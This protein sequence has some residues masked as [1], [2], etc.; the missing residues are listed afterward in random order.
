MDSDRYFA[1]PNDKLKENR[2]LLE[3]TDEQIRRLHIALQCFREFDEN[4]MEV[5]KHK[6]KDE[7]DETGS[8]EPRGPL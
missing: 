5:A 2:T 8:R 3:E 6:L 1:H 7:V 4:T